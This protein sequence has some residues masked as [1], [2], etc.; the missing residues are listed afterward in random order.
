MDQTFFAQRISQML[1]W[2]EIWGNWGTSQHLEL[3][4]PFLKQEA[5]AFKEYWSH[6]RVY[7]ARNNA[8]VGPC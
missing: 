4:K 2:T 6:E 1:N 5:T 8:Q 7:I 3:V